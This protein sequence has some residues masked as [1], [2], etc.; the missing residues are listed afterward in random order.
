M[1]DDADLAGSYNWDEAE[2]QIEL[3]NSQNYKGFNDWRL[4]TKEELD[5]I[6][7]NRNEIGG[8]SAISYWSSTEYIAGLVWIQYFSSGYQ[9]FNLKEYSLRQ[10][11]CVRSL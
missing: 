6:Y 5:E 9:N 10:V 4:P 11:R 3:L 2:E 7:L 8:F 1:I